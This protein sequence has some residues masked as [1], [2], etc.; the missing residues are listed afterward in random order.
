M[1]AV[2]C[3]G[4]PHTGISGSRGDVDDTILDNKTP[5]M[6]V[7]GQFSNS[8][9]LDQ[10]ESLREKMVAENTLLM[11]GGADDHLRMSRAKK[12]R[13]GIT[14]SMVDRCIQVRNGVQVY[15]GWD[16]RQVLSGG[17]WWTGVFG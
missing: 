16:S 15:S 1:T 13:E 7:I 8:C 14:Q 10:I 6:F 12:K 2:V 11:V 5:M 9:T 3:L 17:E 4:F